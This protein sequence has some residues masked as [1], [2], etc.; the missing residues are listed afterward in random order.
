MTA[1]FAD[2]ALFVALLARRDAHH[3]TAT[4]YIRDFEGRIVTTQW[5]M[6]E[7]AN[8]F[9]ASPVR[10]TISALIG[11]MAEDFRFLV[12]DAN[13]VDYREGIALYAQRADKEW[14][15]TDCISI[16]VARRAQIH[17]VLTTDHHFEQAGFEIL[18][19]RPG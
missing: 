15:L 12:I 11:E 17:R 1:V 2:T 5:I 4:E 3:A 6:V 7:L 10:Q 16:V 14:S 13:G 8:F 18:L 19:K 9:A